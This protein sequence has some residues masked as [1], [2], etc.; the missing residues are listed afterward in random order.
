VSENRHGLVVAVHL[1]EANG[2]TEREV[3]ADT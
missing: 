2:G 1:D 3:A